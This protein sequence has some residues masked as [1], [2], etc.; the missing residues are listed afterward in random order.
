MRQARD[1][2]CGKERRQV[3]V[4]REGGGE[5]KLHDLM[6]KEKEETSD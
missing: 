2:S 5:K 6:R 3:L 4:V 1:T